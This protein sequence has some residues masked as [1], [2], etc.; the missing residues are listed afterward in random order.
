MDSKILTELIELKD[1][2]NNIKTTLSEDITSI[3]KQVQNKVDLTTYK[4]TDEESEVVTEIEEIMKYNSS[5]I[6]QFYKYEED[7]IKENIEVK[8]EE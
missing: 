8:G 6:G 2:C 1:K 4:Y 3:A 7:E 5:V